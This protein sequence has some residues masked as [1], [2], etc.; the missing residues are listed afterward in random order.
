MTKLFKNIRK[1]LLSENKTTN[2]LKYAIGEII[3]VVIGILIALQVNNWN[4]SQKVKKQEIQIYTELKSDLL[5]TKKEILNAIIKHKE[6]IK[7]TQSLIYG[8][9]KKEP[10]SKIIYNRFARSSDDFQIIPKTSA[11]EGLKNIGLQILSNDSL[12]IRITNLYQLDLKRIDDKLGNEDPELTISNLLSPF[13]KKYF[14]ADYNQTTKYGFKYSDSITVQKMEI[15]DYDEFLTDN[16][17]LRTIELTLYNRSNKID[18]ETETVIK[19]DKTIKRI[20]KELDKL[21]N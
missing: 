19:I 21:K 20:D 8:I 16:M 7:S 3:L 14:F 6:R 1:N 18:L 17:L 15:K 4:E 5:Q 13:Q 12:R 9:V 11:F 10:N 2:Y